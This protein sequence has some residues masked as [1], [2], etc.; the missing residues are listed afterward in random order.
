MPQRKLPSREIF[1]IKRPQRNSASSALLTAKICTGSWHHQKLSH[2]TLWGQSCVFRELYLDS[3]SRTPSLMFFC[4]FGF[5]GRFDKNFLFLKTCH[6]FPETCR[7]KNM[8]LPSAQN[9]SQTEQRLVALDRENSEP[10]KDQWKRASRFFSKSC[11]YC[12]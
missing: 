12:C 8:R 5:F 10:Q 4:S 6:W 7:N 3:S 11:F 2:V 1:N 9:W